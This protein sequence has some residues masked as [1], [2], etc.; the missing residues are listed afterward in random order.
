MISRSGG[1]PT[2]VW[3][4]CV[5]GGWLSSRFIIA[6]AARHQRAGLGQGSQPGG[7]LSPVLLDV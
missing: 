6:L 1:A 2:I 3:F 5:S 7:V 4:P